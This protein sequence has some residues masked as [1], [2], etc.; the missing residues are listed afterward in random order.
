MTVVGINYE[1]TSNPLIYNGVYVSFSLGKERDE[2]VFNSGNVEVDFKA[3][4]IYAYNLGDI[5]MYS[6]S[7]DHF[8]TDNWPDY[9]WKPDHSLIDENDNTPLVIRKSGTMNLKCW[10]EYFEL[11]LSG[12]K[13]FEARSNHDRE[14]APGQV[15]NLC[16]YDPSTNEYTGRQRCFKIGFILSGQFGIPDNVSILS[17]L[18]VQ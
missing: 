7:C 2:K 9:D 1:E 17:L 3:A 4:L 13:T 18:P 15:I 16:E 11:I 10:P 12:Q 8:I 6:S 5:I 14:F